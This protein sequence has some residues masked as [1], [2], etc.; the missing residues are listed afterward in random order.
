[1]IGCRFLLK[2][3]KHFPLFS[4]QSLLHLTCSR[5]WI[6][7]SQYLPHLILQ[8]IDSHFPSINCLLYGICG[9]QNTSHARLILTS[10]GTFS[11]IMQPRMLEMQAIFLI[12]LISE[13]VLCRSFY[14]WSSW[15]ERESSGWMLIPR[16][17]P[18]KRVSQR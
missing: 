2:P 10:T 14:V 15:Y 3:H 16:Q 6:Y 8:S 9:F 12:V 7:S 1:M 5:A 18:E 17:G 13:S 11:Y 4:S